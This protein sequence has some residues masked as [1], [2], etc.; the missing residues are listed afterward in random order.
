[1]K[2]GREDVGTLFWSW[3]TGLSG[4]DHNDRGK[5]EVPKKSHIL[6]ETFFSEGSGVPPIPPDGQT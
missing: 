2:G 6:K 1:M 5:V 4:I 3:D